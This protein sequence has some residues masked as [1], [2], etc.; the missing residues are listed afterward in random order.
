MQSLVLLSTTQ[1]LECSSKA[2]ASA[3][4]QALQIGSIW[5]EITEQA[6]ALSFFQQ[7]C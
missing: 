4:L 1:S 2:V 5:S 7:Q 6:I 3:A